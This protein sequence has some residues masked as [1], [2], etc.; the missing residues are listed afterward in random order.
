MSI[1]LNDYDTNV[2]QNTPHDTYIDNIFFYMPVLYIT[3]FQQYTKDYF[4]KSLYLLFGSLY[5][6]YKVNNIFFFVHFQLLPYRCFS[7]VYGLNTLL[8][9]DA[10][11]FC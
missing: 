2:C 3:D 4:Q 1:I 6:I 9:Y 8:A 11:F 7:L 5:G 10:Y